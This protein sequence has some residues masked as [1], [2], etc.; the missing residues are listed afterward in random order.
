MAEVLRA[1][2]QGRRMEISSIFRAML[3][4]TM[5]PEMLRRSG[6]KQADLARHLQLDPSSLIKTIKGTR[7]LKA[8]EMVKIEEFFATAGAAPL[9]DKS[10]IDSRGSNARNRRQV[11]VFGYEARDLGGHVA[12][13]PEDVVEWIDPPP[14]WNGLGELVAVRIFGSAMAPRLFEGEIVYAQLKLPPAAGRDVLIEFQ[15]GSGLVRTYTGERDG[16]LFCH[17]WTPDEEVRFRSTEFK[18]LHAIVWRR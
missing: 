16:Q 12:M 2:D 6:K 1:I 13:G 14:F 15:D 5:I 11:R 9:T 10:P 17:T 4:V 3:D 8:H 7:Q 18:A